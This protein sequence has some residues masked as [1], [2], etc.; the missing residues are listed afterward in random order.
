MRTEDPPRGQT[1][2]WDLGLLSLVTFFLGQQKESDCQPGHSR[3]R[4]PHENITRRVSARHATLAA[5]IT[6]ALL[7]ALGPS[8]AYG[9]AGPRPDAR[10]DAVEAATVTPPTIAP[11]SE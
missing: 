6:L 8:L 11:A 1:Q 7:L 4:L 3:R 5:S 10:A 2:K 9:R